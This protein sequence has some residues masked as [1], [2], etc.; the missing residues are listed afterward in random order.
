[1]VEA[2][3]RAGQ[4]P[5]QL[6]QGEGGFREGEEQIRLEKHQNEASGYES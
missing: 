4:R 1:M 6:P 5:R 2:C 3:G